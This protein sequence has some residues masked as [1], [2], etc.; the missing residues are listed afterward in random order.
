M[1]SE[2]CS[3]FV[4]V[5]FLIL[6]R[7][8][9]IQNNRWQNSQSNDWSNRWMQCT[10]S[11]AWSYGR[12]LCRFRPIFCVRCIVHGTVLEATM[13]LPS[14]VCLMIDKTFFFSFPM[15]IFS[16]CIES[17]FTGKFT[18]GWG[19]WSLFLTQESN[20]LFERAPVATTLLGSVIDASLWSFLKKSHFYAKLQWPTWKW[21][22]V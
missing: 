11:D 16:G 19:Q 18:I 3:V 14:R 10:S 4:I 12:E 9:T 6:I 13:H 8:H 7:H 22:R 21:K 5:Q 20:L 1:I 15:S 17:K 2:N